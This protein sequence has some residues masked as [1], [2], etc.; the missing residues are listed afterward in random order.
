MPESARSLPAPTS[1]G[2]RATE[3]TLYELIAAIQEAVG[4]DADDLVI[5]TIVHLL[6]SGQVKFIGQRQDVKVGDR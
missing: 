3:T 4:P 2:A 5:A 6:N 1:T